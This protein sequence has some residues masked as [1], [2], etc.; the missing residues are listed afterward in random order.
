MIGIVGIVVVVGSVIAAAVAVSEARKNRALVTLAAADAARAREQWRDRVAE[1]NGWQYADLD[2]T[3]ADVF[4]AKVRPAAR[5]RHTVHYREVIRG[6]LRGLCF[7]VFDC[8]FEFGAEKL[9][10]QAR[11]YFL[12]HRPGTGLDGVDVWSDEVTPPE[13]T[14]LVLTDRVVAAMKRLGID[15]WQ[16]RESTI[17]VHMSRLPQEKTGDLVEKLHAIRDL[18]DELPTSVV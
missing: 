12:L 16:I 11:T 9:P 3:I 7:E 10:D 18:A 6:E 2:P 4:P 1:R 5:G 13:H 8:T 14:S 15:H 17:V